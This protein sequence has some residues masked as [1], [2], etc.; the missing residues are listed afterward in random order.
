M[1]FPSLLEFIHGAVAGACRDGIITYTALDASQDPLA[2]VH[3]PSSHQVHPKPLRPALVSADQKLQATVDLADK[4]RMQTTVRVNCDPMP[5]GSEPASH[6]PVDIVQQDSNCSQKAIQEHQGVHMVQVADAC[7]ASC[8]PN[9]ADC[10]DSVGHTLADTVR[11]DQGVRNNQ[12]AGTCLALC[13]QNPI[14]C[15]E[16]VSIPGSTKEAPRILQADDACAENKQPAASR[17][18]PVSEAGA[19]AHTHQHAY[20][21]NAGA[22]ND[23]PAGSTTSLAAAVDGF[24]LQP[25]PP[26]CHKAAADA[27]SYVSPAQPGAYAGI[28]G[29][30]GNAK[31]H[32][33]A[34]ITGS[35]HAADAEAAAVTADMPELRVPGQSGQKAADPTSIPNASAD[36]LHQQTLDVVASPAAEQSAPGL[37]PARVSPASGPLQP[38]TAGKDVESTDHGVAHMVAAAVEPSPDTNDTAAIPGASPVCAAAEATELAPNVQSLPEVKDDAMCMEA[39]GRLSTDNQAPSARLQEIP[40]AEPP[41]MATDPVEMPARD[42]RNAEQVTPAQQ[43]LRTHHEPARGHH[44][45]AARLSGRHTSHRDAHGDALGLTVAVMSASPAGATSGRPSRE[46]ALLIPAAADPQPQCPDSIAAGGHVT[47]IGHDGIMEPEGPSTR[48]AASDQPHEVGDSQGKKRPSLH[49]SASPHVKAGSAP[50]GAADAICELAPAPPGVSTSEDPVMASWPFRHMGPPARDAKISSADPPQR[51]DKVSSANGMPAEPASEAQCLV[52]SPAEQGAPSSSVAP[53]GVHALAALPAFCHHVLHDPDD[54][55]S[56]PR[57]L[58]NPGHADCQSPTS[59]AQTELQG[60]AE[61]SPAR[62]HLKDTEAHEEREAKPAA[63]SPLGVEDVVRDTAD[64]DR[65]ELKAASTLEWSVAASYVSATQP[66]QQMPQGSPETAATAV[67]AVAS[68]ADSPAP[69]GPPSPSASWD[70]QQLPY[71]SQEVPQRAPEAAA[72]ATTA[73]AAASPAHHSPP[74]P[75]ASYRQLTSHQSQKMPQGAPEAAATAAPAPGRAPS[76]APS[77]APSAPASRSSQQLSHQ[78]TELPLNAP[79]SQLSQEWP[80]G[81]LKVMATAAATAPSAAASEDSQRPSQPGSPPGSDAPTLVPQFSRDAFGSL[82]RSD[83]GQSAPHCKSGDHQQTADLQQLKADNTC[84]KPPDSGSVHIAP[85]FQ[86]SD[87]RQRSVRQ[88]LKADNA[89]FRQS[90]TEQQM[91]PLAEMNRSSNVSDVQ[92][93]MQPLAEMNRSKDALNTRRDS[94]ILPGR[95]AQPGYCP[96]EQDAGVFATIQQPASLETIPMSDMQVSISGAAGGR[97]KQY[98]LLP[99][100][101]EDAAFHALDAEGRG[102]VTVRKHEGLINLNLVMTDGVRPSQEMLRL[103]TM[104]KP[105]RAALPQRDSY[106]TAIADADQP[107]QAVRPEDRST[108]E[109]MDAAAKSAA[110]GASNQHSFARSAR[111]AGSAALAEQLSNH[112]AG[113]EEGEAMHAKTDSAVRSTAFGASNK[114]TFPD[115]GRED[116]DQQGSRAAADAVRSSFYYHLEE[117][118]PAKVRSATAHPALLEAR[119]GVVQA[120]VWCA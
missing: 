116:V 91:H 58:G 60:S 31:A 14:E 84:F 108:H 109:E 22:A 100:I 74:S 1:V 26:S 93:Q 68:P 98:C 37:L 61:P 104:N 30:T 69:L 36:A 12:M 5:A 113:R 27:L 63:A 71:Q 110:L 76:A 86:S 15:I 87:H 13:H 16:A 9:V 28:C 114:R 83:C 11:G 52:V 56:M 2:V 29:R 70:R 24:V 66:S 47:A 23:T 50:R 111:S 8:H 41:G 80:Q 19:A 120:H 42:T 101:T 118:S 48:H 119:S 4:H 39:G 90:P 62:E 82:P 35:R 75:A 95:A 45:N 55:A 106:K 40:E 99:G 117:G 54:T 89:R 85:H 7:P 92:S 97:P 64:P 94:G 17:T 77:H 78:S 38:S 46:A 25:Q 72:F 105:A 102:H 3:Q 53:S 10:A 49:A 115:V 65:E 43:H 57:G 73:S 96:V 103:R 88:Q 51:P 112:H 79:T 34:I 44:S 67:A 18:I 32:Q 59:A 21:Q 20:V 107:A 6:V 33:G 81:P